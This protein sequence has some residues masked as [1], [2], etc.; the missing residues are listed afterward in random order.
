MIDEEAFLLGQWVSSHKL[1]NK[2][3][4]FLELADTFY[5]TCKHNTYPPVA[6]L[7]LSAKA[8]AVILLSRQTSANSHMLQKEA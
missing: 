3:K 6:L 4:V 2:E 8:R 7:P 1:K 5:S